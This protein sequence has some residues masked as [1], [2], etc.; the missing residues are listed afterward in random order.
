MNKRIALTVGAAIAV[1]SA[2]AVI[3]Q[4]GLLDGS[5]LPKCVA[6]TSSDMG[7]RATLLGDRPL[8]ISGNELVV[9]SSGQALDPDGCVQS[10]GI[11]RHLAVSPGT[12]AAF[13]VDQAGQDVLNVVRPN[14]VLP[15]ASGIEIN[16]PA[17]SPAG[18]LAWSEN[19]QVLKVMSAD[20]SGISGV[21]LPT[22]GVAAFS[23][24]FVGEQRLM[25]VV[26]EQVKGAPPEDESLNNLWLFDLE[27]GRWTRRTSFSASDD[28]W[29]GIRTP[30]IAPDGSV[31]FVRISANASQTKEP[32][33]ELWRYSGHRA[34]KVRTLESEMYLAG[35]SD[36]RL[37]WNV[38]SRTCG[39][40]GLFVESAPGLDQIGCGAVMTDPVAFADPDLLVESEDGSVSVAPEGDRLTDL[41]IVIGDL[42]SRSDARRIAQRLDRPARVIGHEDARTALRPGAWGLMVELAAGIPV[43]DDLEAVR[44]RLGTCDC[45][46][47]LAPNV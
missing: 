5:S 14:G 35:F 28:R 24:L 17:W 44:A 33:F 11:L 9:A 38:P 46:A 34:E 27:A 47:W 15:I 41:V 20:G 32:V 16:H 4:T 22:G 26:Q 1:I 6:D 42:E 2:S 19:L 8:A 30:V 29:V 40:W 45:G 18:Q 10:A 23:P 21:V 43:D 39:D 25:V 3:A 37:L 7:A 13:V 12:G 36:D 31:Y